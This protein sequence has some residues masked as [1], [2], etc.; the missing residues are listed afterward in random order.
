MIC[1][2][3]EFVQ[4][5][6][7]YI[8]SIQTSAKESEKAVAVIEKFVQGKCCDSVDRCYVM[9]DLLKIEKTLKPG[10]GIYWKILI[11]KNVTMNCRAILR[12]F[13]LC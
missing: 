4:I 8:R 3:C 11:F 6:L 10:I 13:T 9:N 5:C 12:R 7:Q 1:L 2:F